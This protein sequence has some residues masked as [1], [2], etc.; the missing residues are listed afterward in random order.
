TNYSSFTVQS[1]ENVSRGKGECGY[2]FTNIDIQCDSPSYDDSGNVKFYGTFTVENGPD[3]GVLRPHTSAING[4][5]FDIDVPGT[6][7][8][9]SSTSSCPAVTMTTTP[10]G[11]AFAPNQQATYC[12]ELEVPI[13]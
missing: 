7:T 3:L 11:N 6:L 4:Q 12:F 5:D 8:I 13:G 9:L 10:N 2:E 1:R